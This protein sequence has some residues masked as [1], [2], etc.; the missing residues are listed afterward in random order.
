M[1]PQNT[2][3]PTKGRLLALLDQELTAA[4]SRAVHD[5]LATCKDCRRRLADIEVARAALLAVTGAQAAPRS[6]PKNGCERRVALTPLGPSAF[7]LASVDEE[8]P[9][10]EFEVC[11]EYY[12]ADS[13]PRLARFTNELDP[14]FQLHPPGWSQAAG[15]TQLQRTAGILAAGDDPRELEIREVSSGVFELRCALPL[16]PEGAPALVFARRN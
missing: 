9:F 13:V 16:N 8:V 15:E 10:S 12:D 11:L 5:H 3:E 1:I 7:R 6:R 2:C 4:E 14:Y